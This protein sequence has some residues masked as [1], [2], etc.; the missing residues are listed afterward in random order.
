V[1]SLVV[2]KISEGFNAAP[3]PLFLFTLHFSPR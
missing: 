1:D 3:P 2:V